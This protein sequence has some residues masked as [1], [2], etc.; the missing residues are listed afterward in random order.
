MTNTPPDELRLATR[1]TPTE[2]SQTAQICLLA[3]GAGIHWSNDEKRA[4]IGEGPHKKE[5]PNPIAYPGGLNAFRD[6]L[7][8]TCF[9]TACQTEAT[10]AA[11]RRFEG[12]HISDEREIAANAKAMSTCV[13]IDG[14]P[15]IFMS[16]RFVKEFIDI[17][18]ESEVVNS[19][20]VSK[21]P[22]SGNKTRLLLSWNSISG[23][24]AAAMWWGSWIAERFNGRRWGSVVIFAN[25]IFR[26]KSPL[27]FTPLSATMKGDVATVETQPLLPAS[28][29]S[30]PIDS[31][32]SGN[33]N[34]N[35]SRSPWTFQ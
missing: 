14:V 17:V 1:N 22:S 29:H 34:D 15:D 32:V 23:G 25:L 19:C 30:T 5:I 3:V 20:E 13:L 8:S 33:S 6:M 2:A 7:N 12:E 27:R 16:D 11:G 35:H 24:E 10:L 26:D 9:T 21:I 31:I 18:F 4:Y 28:D